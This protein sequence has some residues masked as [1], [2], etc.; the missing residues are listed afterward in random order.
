MSTRIGRYV[1]NDDLESMDVEKL[2]ILKEGCEHFIKERHRE[3]IHSALTKINLLAHSYGFDI[4]V[5]DSDGCITC[6]NE[7]TLDIRDREV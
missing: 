1:F 5:E 4:C 6:L 2:A 3:E 7:I